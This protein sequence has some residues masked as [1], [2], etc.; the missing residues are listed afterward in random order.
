MYTKIKYKFNFLDVNECLVKENAC[1]ER[2]FCENTIGSYTCYECDP[3]C[4]SCS[5]KGADKCIG[6]CSRGYKALPNPLGSETHCVDVNECEESS[7]PVCSEKLKCVNTIGGYECV[8]KNN[9]FLIYLFLIRKFKK[10]L[11]YRR[12]FFNFCTIPFTF[13][14]F[15]LIL[16]PDIPKLQIISS[17]RFI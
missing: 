16:I 7:S 3:G 5:G 2:E 11:F 12:Q 13:Y 9:R 10:I 17:E 8:G 6:E 4:K 14:F 15:K 1:K